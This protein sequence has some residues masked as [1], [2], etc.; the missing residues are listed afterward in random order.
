MTRLNKLTLAI[1]EHA[2]FL[3]L[4][5]LAL[6][7]ALSWKMFWRSSTDAKVQAHL[8]DK[9]IVFQIQTQSGQICRQFQVSRQRISSRWGA[10]PSPDLLITF[11]NAAVGTR[12]MTAN[13]KRLAFM[14]GLQNQEVSLLG[15]L[16]LFAWYVE[17]GS[18][19]NQ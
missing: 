7:C 17:L 15:D 12:I 19:L 18:L 1:R 5:F 9:Q 2:W 3:S 14:Q 11:T 10:H 4:K 6:L 16:S 13:G 8:G